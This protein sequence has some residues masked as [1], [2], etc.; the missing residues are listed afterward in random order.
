MESGDIQRLKKVWIYG[1]GSFASELEDFLQNYGIKVIGRITRENFRSFNETGGHELY[2]ADPGPVL[3]GVFNHR[4]DPIEI[5]EFLESLG[6]TDVVSPAT[7]V[8]SFQ[9]KDF[10]KYYLNGDL[11]IQPHLRE[12]LEFVQNK[13]HLE[14]LSSLH[15]QVYYNNNP[16]QHT[17]HHIYVII[18]I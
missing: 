6:I 9:N 2:S 11:A 17:I 10:N 12:D 14:N 15:Q 16:Y 4:D 8:N 13:Y 7:I 5:V 18:N 1:G 3:I